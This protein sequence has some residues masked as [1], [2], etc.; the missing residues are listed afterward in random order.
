ML[1]L[2]Y[3][4]FAH[5]DHAGHK[6]ASFTLSHPRTFLDM[7]HFDHFHL[8]RNYIIHLVLSVIFSKK[9]KLFKDFF[10]TSTGK[11]FSEVLIYLS[12]NPQYDNKLFNDLRVQYKK[13]P[14]AE[15]VKNMLFTQ[16]VLNV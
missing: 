5:F 3:T 2:L 1:G 14:R 11:S 13:I 10:W 6:L 9:T 7:D 8:G 15:H 4:D 16:I 12:I